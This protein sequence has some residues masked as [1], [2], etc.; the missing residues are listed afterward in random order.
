M[1]FVDLR[2]RSGI[3]HVVF[4]PQVSPEAYKIADRLRPEWVIRATGSVLRRPI[5]SENP[6]MATGTVEV[7]VRDVEILNSSLTPPFYI[8][9]DVE[10]D[11]SLRLKYRY[12]DLR[13]PVMQRNL[14][15]RHQVVKYIRDFLDARD[16]W[17]IETPILIKSTPEG[18]RDYLVPSRVQPG[19]FFALPQ[20]PQIFKQLFMV[21]GFDRYAQIVRCFRDED[22]RAD[23]QPEFT[24]LDMEMSFVQADDVMNAVEGCVVNIFKEALDI[25][26]EHI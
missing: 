22:L 4:N 2:D 1:I 18:A 16:F 13:R 17:E 14:M 7:M 20:S 26:I 6:N 9:D 11:E 25:D 8:T 15:L 23:R 3:A 10:A 5:G 19:T 21:A 12:L 24:Q